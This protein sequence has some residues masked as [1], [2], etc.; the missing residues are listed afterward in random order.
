MVKF[1]HY[2]LFNDD[3][4]IDRVITTCSLLKEHNAFYEFLFQFTIFKPTEEVKQWDRKLGNHLT[5]QRL[6]AEPFTTSILKTDVVMINHHF[7]SLVTLMGIESSLIE[8]KR[9]SNK[10]IDELCYEIQYLIQEE[11][12][13]ARSIM[14]NEIM[15]NIFF[16]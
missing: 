12:Q 7:L 2:R 3:N 13:K 10:L 1:K 4:Q 6:C 16:N 14:F 8:N 9:M 5:Y 15:N 11:K